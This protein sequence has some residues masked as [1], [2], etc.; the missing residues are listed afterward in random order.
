MLATT[1]RRRNWWG[2]GCAAALATSA[3]CPAAA[4]SAAA[5]QR[6]S[7]RRAPS[8]VRV[9]SGGDELP[10]IRTACGLTTMLSLPEEARE[11]ICGDLFDPQTG[12]GGFVIQRSGRDLFL[13]PLRAAGASNLFVKTERATYGFELEVVAPSRAMRIVRVELANH[14]PPASLAAPRPPS[15]TKP[16]GAPGA[17]LL[18]TASSVATGGR[19]Y[20]RCDTRN[21]ADVPVTIALARVRDTS[22]SK[23][24]DAGVPL[25]LTLAPHAKKVVVVPL[26][27]RPSASLELTFVDETG[28]SL[29]EVRPFARDE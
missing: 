22:G 28:A 25:R 5:G 17:R 19:F 23:P 13:K 8:V 16:P 7:P 6:E 20:L 27:E 26:G 18:V 14:P 4:D 9:V 10:V 2:L 15:E 11:A 1:V 24:T 12:A 3:L 29:V 21:P